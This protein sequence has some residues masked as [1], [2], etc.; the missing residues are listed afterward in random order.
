MLLALPIHWWYQ[1]AITSDGIAFVSLFPKGPE[2][3]QTSALEVWKA[4]RDTAYT[5]YI[6][7]LI[8]IGVSIKLFPLKAEWFRQQVPYVVISLLI[9]TF[10][11]ALAG[12]L[13]D[14]FYVAF[15]VL[16]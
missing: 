12:L 3:V 11:F 14:L 6:L 10:S 1:Q 5:V 2:I 4:G 9:S 16:S 13:I 7:L 15:M 8:T